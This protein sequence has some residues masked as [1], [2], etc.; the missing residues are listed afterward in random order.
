MKKEEIINNIDNPKYLEKLYRE[1]KTTFKKEFNLIYNIIQE[2]PA[3]QVWYERLNFESEGISWGTKGELTFVIIASFIA[4][5]IAKIPDF[6]SI[7]DE[8]FYPRNLAFI[9][10]PMLTM[11]FS[12]RQNLSSKKLLIST[13][14]ILLSVFYIN[15]LPNDRKSDTLMLACI[16]LPLFLWT[17]LGFAFVGNNLKSFHRRLDFLRY[18]GDM[19]V[20]TAIILIAGALLT[21]GTIGLFSLID[22]KIED[23]YSRNVVVWGLAASPIFGTYLVQTNPQLVNK[24]S[25]IIAKIFTPL[26]FIT[27]V[28]Y[29]IAVIMTGKDPY[30][31]REFLLIFNAL[32]IGVM[33]IV[34]FSIAENS[35][36]SESRIV[37]WLLFGLTVVTIIV[38]G[39]ALSAILFRI[40]EWGITPNRLA[41][42]GGNI[43]ILINLLFVSYRLFK[44]VKGKNEIED[45]EKNI[46]Y[47]LPLY[48]NWTVVVT[49]V[50][51]LIFNFK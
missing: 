37:I 13:A 19:V 39:V 14:L 49:F 5:F 26:V 9:V 7:K 46:A 48:S 23:F 35:K 3:A 21:A 34:I 22:V 12:W 38:N 32:L 20:M 27:L 36:N 8:Y 2:Y 28:I 17:V 45:I 15:I 44:T 10:F 30:N 29:L 6:T 40:S 42:L 11:Y 25:P 16:H 18:N 33:A 24:V 50:F 43:L 1:D 47:F 51:P 4:G 31:D 41:V